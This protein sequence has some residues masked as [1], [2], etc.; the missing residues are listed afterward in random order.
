LNLKKQFIL[1]GAGILLLCILFFFVRT[2]PNK[3]VLASSNKDS[4]AQKAFNVKLFIQQEKAKLSPNNA[5]LVS[6][7]ENSISRGD[8]L[9]Q[10]IKAYEALANFWKD[11][12]KLYEA[13]VFYISEAAKL[14]NSEKNLTFAARL[15]LDNLR[16]EKDELKLAWETGEAIELFNR[17]I[18]INPT[19]DDLRIGLGSSYIYGKGRN[20]DPQ[21]TMKGIQE[22]LA[23]VRKDSSNLK[24]Q[25]MLGVGGVVSG[26]YIKAIDRLEKVAAAEPNNVEAVA[27]L[28]DAYAG[29]GKK[30]EAIKWYN[31]SKRLI[32]DTHY[33]QEVDERIKKLK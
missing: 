20:G 6:K 18:K 21:E 26:Q 1:T 33:T 3:K 2:T 10:Q 11:S 23:V 22:L 5:I 14:E 29:I 17:A 9:T 32:N 27:Y 30:A 24:A 16:G 19:N 8:V 15:Y 7:L 13:Y 25:L 4:I 28:A 31:I 12:A